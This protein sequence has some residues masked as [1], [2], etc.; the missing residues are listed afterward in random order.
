M[1]DGQD[2]N[3]AAEMKGVLEWVPIVPG[4]VIHGLPFKVLVVRVGAMMDHLRNLLA[5]ANERR[6]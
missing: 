4:D 3:S 1:R 2:V 6:N 5:L